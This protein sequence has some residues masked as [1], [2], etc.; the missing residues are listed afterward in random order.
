MI[1][2]FLALVPTHQ[3]TPIAALLATTGLV[4]FRACRLR[5]LP[6]FM[7]L[8]IG[9]WWATGAREFFK[10]HLHTLI[11]H[12][13]KVDAVVSQN[14]TNRV[15]GNFDHRIVADMTLLAGAT[16]WLLAIFGARHLL[17]ETRR[18][19]PAAVLAVAPMPLLV[20]QTY[21]GEMLL[22]VQL[23]ALPFTAFFAASFLLGD[24]R[25]R[26]ALL[27]DDPS[28]PDVS[29]A[30]RAVI[31]CVCL[32]LCALFL[33]ARYGNEKINHFTADDVAGVEHLYALAQPGATLVAGSGNLPW[34][35]RDYEHHRYRTVVKMPSWGVTADPSAS[36][37]PLLKD[38][39]DTMNSSRRQRKGR[40][41][42]S[43]LPA[44]Q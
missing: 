11:D 27:T 4:V 6:P 28:P 32:G 16:I 3:L 22:R 43:W 31:V 25:P 14:V 21:G 1:F 2:L 41:A 5:W 24:L 39:R 33:F 26:Y 37:A 19:L 13:G 17:R 10:G 9:C 34:K 35:Y 36:L 20:L 29:R 23:F 15:A 12:A 40:T 18:S 8:A 42:I 7:A 38:V 44:L 30:R